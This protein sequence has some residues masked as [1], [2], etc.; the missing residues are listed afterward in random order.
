MTKVKLTSKMRTIERK[1]KLRESR[2]TYDPWKTIDEVVSELKALEDEFGM[3]SV[4]FYRQFVAG[5]VG[6]SAQFIRW[7]SLYDAYNRLFARVN[8][9]KASR[10]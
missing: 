5:R 1:R 2:A 10:H 4:E 9:A 8:E 3:S 6:D 7:A